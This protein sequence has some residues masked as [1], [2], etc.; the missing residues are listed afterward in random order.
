MNKHPREF[1]IRQGAN[2]PHW[3]LD[4]AIY[5]VTFRLADSLPAEVLDQW[6]REREHIVDRAADL[7]RTISE[8]ESERLAE[9]HSDRIEQWLDQGS[10]S[11]MLREARFALLVRDAMLHFDGQRY[12]L[13]AW[14]IMPNHVH[15]VLR[16]RE[17]V[18]LSSVLHSWK[19]FTGTRI[20]LALGGMGAVW[21]KESYDHVVRGEA[22]WRAQV[23]YVAENPARAGLV[24]WPWV[25]RCGERVPLASWGSKDTAA[26]GG[27]T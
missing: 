6:R 2:L 18:D 27:A 3:R 26:E 20:R 9:L 1:Q 22:D 16:T 5:A 23:R 8:H 14:C 10:G 4:G 12:D 21:Q 7:G 11:C 13:H 17:G 19:S 25:W 15:A 24:G